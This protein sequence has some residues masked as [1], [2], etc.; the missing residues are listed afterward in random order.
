VQRMHVQRR[1]GARGKR[2]DAGSEFRGER[3]HA[4]GV[5]PTDADPPGVDA[6]GCDA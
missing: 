5:A 4:A 6:A 1:G 3:V 2:G